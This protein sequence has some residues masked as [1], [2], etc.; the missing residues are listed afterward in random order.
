[1]VLICLRRWSYARIAYK[2]S[3]VYSSTAVVVQ[4]SEG[5]NE[6]VPAGVRGQG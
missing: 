1:M 3:C 4:S 6:A 5:V 2:Y